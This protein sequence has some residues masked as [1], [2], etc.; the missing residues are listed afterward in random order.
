MRHPDSRGNKIVQ[1]SLGA[2]LVP[3]LSA[4]ILATLQ[5]YIEE[6]RQKP[7]EV[8]M[9]EA[10]IIVFSVWLACIVQPFYV[11]SHLRAL[12]KLMAEP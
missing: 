9:P 8:S 2:L 7:L 10:L 4:S 12:R 5:R 1:R 11:Q 3:A 6:F